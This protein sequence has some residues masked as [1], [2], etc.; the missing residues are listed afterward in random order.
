MSKASRLKRR[1]IILRLHS[2]LRAV[3]CGE[4]NLQA[5]R[6]PATA[7]DPVTHRWRASPVRTMVVHTE[8]GTAP[9]VGFGL[10]PNKALVA[11]AEFLSNKEVV[12][13]V[14]ALRKCGNLLE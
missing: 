13:D 12:V 6:V 3:N 1:R 8:N 2:W 7:Q 11:L 4:L 9:A 5:V 14:T 10:T